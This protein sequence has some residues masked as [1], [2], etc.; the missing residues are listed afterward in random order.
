MELVGGGLCAETAHATALVAA[1]KHQIPSTNLQGILKL[2]IPKP[3][4]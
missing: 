3:E 2:Q 1:E 4:Y